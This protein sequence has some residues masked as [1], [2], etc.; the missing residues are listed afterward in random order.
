M[1]TAFI[2]LDYIVDIVD[3]S[4]KIAASAGQ[5]KERGV[6]AKAN[7]ALKIAHDKGWLSILVK[8]GF[9]RGYK[10]QPKNSP[11]FGRANEL[12]ALALDGPGTGFHEDL[13]SDFAD[14]IMVKPRVSPFYGTGLE[15]ALRA[16]RIERLIVAGVSSAWAVEAATRDA[17]DRDYEVYIAEDACA[18]ANTEEHEAAMKRLA[19]IA[20][21]IHVGDMR[22]L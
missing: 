21:I 22:T 7:E 9:S 2:G 5:V 3:P 11:L 20:K 10:D 12:D 16:N 6:I 14:L 15:A 17:H 19:R 13:R 1:K 4:G 18:A 8:V